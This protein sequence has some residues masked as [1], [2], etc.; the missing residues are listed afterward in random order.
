MSA[1]TAK[2]IDVL[3]EDFQTRPTVYVIDGMRIRTAYVARHP[4]SIHADMEVIY[5][6][7]AT[8]LSDLPF[9]PE[10]TRVN[11]RD[12]KEDE[13]TAE[14]E[15]LTRCWR[16]ATILARKLTGAAL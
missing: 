10:R 13:Q 14:Q 8:S 12:V 5:R 6:D 15:L 16:T 2:S 3:T 11:A 1:T 4:E 9:Q 7:T